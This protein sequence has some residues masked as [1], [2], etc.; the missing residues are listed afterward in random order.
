M[1]YNYIFISI[2]LLIVWFKTDAFLEYVKL[3]R[4]SKLFKVDKFEKE[5]LQD[6]ELNYHLY[7]RKYHNNFFTRLITCP[8]CLS[9]WLCLPI[10][11]YT[12]SLGIYCFHV[13]I[14]LTSYY[15]L[16]KLINIQ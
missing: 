5:K 2:L 13:L 9:V 3:F 6:F 7:L 4:L 11:F 16:S 10:L 1:K 15:L 8:I 14:I 12:F